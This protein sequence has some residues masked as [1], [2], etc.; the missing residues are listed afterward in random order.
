MV[1]VDL[2]QSLH[3]ISCIFGRNGTWRICTYIVRIY[4]KCDAIFFPAFHNVVIHKSCRLFLD[5]TISTYYVN[6]RNSYFHNE[7]S[8]YQSHEREIYTIDIPTTI[9]LLWWKQTIEMIFGR[10]MHGAMRKMFAMETFQLF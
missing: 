8:P 10:A 2:I 6:W 4:V 3:A 1:L 9:T 7:S 5:K